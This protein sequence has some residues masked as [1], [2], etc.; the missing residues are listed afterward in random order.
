ML[1]VS[2]TGAAFLAPERR[3]MFVGSPLHLEAMHSSSRLVRETAP[4][5]PP[6]AR[7]VRIEPSDLQGYA[8]VAVRFESVFAPAPPERGGDLLQTAIC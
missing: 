4:S 8:T 5:L 6:E 1:N 3:R 7:V 2:E